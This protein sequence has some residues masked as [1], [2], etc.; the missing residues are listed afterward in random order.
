M[1]RIPH[2]LCFVLLLSLTAGAQITPSDGPY[3]DTFALP[4]PL[5]APIKAVG[6]QVT[7][8]VPGSVHIY[9]SVHRTWTQVPVGPGA[10]VL[11]SFNDQVIIQ[12]GNTIHGY[13]ARTGAVNTITVSP[14]AVVDTG[15]NFS[16][17]ITVVQDGTTVYGFSSFLGQWVPQTIASNTPVISTGSHIALV[18][19]GVNT[20]GFST[21]YGTWVPNPTGAGALIST[22]GVQGLAILPNEVRGFAAQSNTWASFPMA[23][24]QAASLTSQRGYALLIDGNTALFFSGWTGQFT[25]YVGAS[26]L[27]VFA[28]RH[29][30]ALLDG[31]TLVGYAAGVSTTDT[32]TVSGIPGVQSNHETIMVTDGNQVYGFSGVKGAFSAPLVGSYTTSVFRSIGFAQNANVAYAYSPIL[33]AW[34]QAPAVNITNVTLIRNGVVL[35]HAGG[36]EAFTSRYGTWHSLPIPGGTSIFH[37]AIFVAVNG[38]RMDVFDARLARWTTMIGNA[39]PT[40]SRWRVVF[41]ASD[42]TNGYGYSLFHG[43]WDVTTIQG[44]VIQVKANSEA[45]FIETPTHVH[46]FAGYGTLTNLTRYA[47]FSRF[48]VRGTIFRIKQV[49]PPGSIVWSALSP[50]PAVMSIGSLGTLFVDP[51]GMVLTP[52]GVIPTEGMLDVAFTIPNDPALNGT[53]IHMQDLILP[54]GAAPYV[55]NSISPI[56]F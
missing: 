21:F 52:L 7:V 53:D 47:E 42:G 13:S 4:G 20:W 24:A 37:G 36:F 12:D 40:T 31:T 28:D 51:V 30:A 39:P 43:S 32:I 27:A 45:G 54:P 25:S 9:T 10:V 26:P 22:S 29:V 3:W 8:Q 19:D 44:P 11:N 50:A 33:N 16:S 17:W 35:E 48:A 18:D 2:I 56:I 38:N 46:V 55:T 5:T 15:P 23:G 34:S 49:G 41:L 6:S 1:Y 14:G